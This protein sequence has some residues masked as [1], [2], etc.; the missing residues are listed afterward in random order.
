MDGFIDDIISI[1]VM[2]VSE[3]AND[4]GNNLLGDESWDTDDLNSP[5][6][7]LLSKEEK[8]KPASH[9]AT[10]YPLA[11]DI[12]STKASMDGLIN[13]IITITV[14]DKHWTARANTAALLVIHTLFQ[15]LHPSESL[16]RDDPLSLRKLVGNGRTSREQEMPRVGH[17]QSLYEIFSTWIETNSL[18]QQH[19]RGISFNKNYDKHSGI[20][21]WKDRPLITCHPTRTILLKLATTLSKEEGKWVPQ[22]LQIWHRIDIDRSGKLLRNIPVSSGTRGITSITSIQR[23]PGRRYMGNM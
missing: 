15:P 16:K 17:K 1:T 2:T 4:L 13:D 19:K 9:I 14:D 8:Q 21:N 20:I 22:R 12:T 7:S 10:A 6:Q 18:D 23:R 5:H 11:V 3:A